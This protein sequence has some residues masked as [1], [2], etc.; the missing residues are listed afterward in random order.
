MPA[1]PQAD[2][3]NLSLSRR[4][5]QF[6]CRCRARVLASKAMA[7]GEQ[8][9]RRGGV[10]GVALN[11]FDTATSHLLKGYFDPVDDHEASPLPDKDSHTFHPSSAS[12]NQAGAA[13]DHSSKG[14]CVD[15]KKRMEREHI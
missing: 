14:I 7:D 12:L 3:S 5:K 9:G 8:I 11:C 10:V 1:F 13:E 6:A 4:N 15:E 2:R